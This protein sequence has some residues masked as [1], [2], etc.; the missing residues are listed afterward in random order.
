MLNEDTHFTNGPGTCFRKPAGMMQR[1]E[2]ESFV[3]P[4]IVIALRNDIRKHGGPVGLAQL[5]AKTGV[6]SLSDCLPLWTVTVEELQGQLDDHRRL[7]CL[8][9]R[10]AQ[11]ACEAKVVE[12]E[13][14]Q[15]Q[16]FAEAPLPLSDLYLDWCMERIGAL[17][18]ERPGTCPR[19][20][21]PAAHLAAIESLQDRVRESLRGSD[22]DIAT[23][24]VQDPS[25][26]GVRAGRAKARPTTTE[27]L[28]QPIPRLGAEL[29]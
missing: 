12:R 25:G 4:E 19:G 28:H 7:G 10:P 20:A 8:D 14:V 29:R 26:R 1:G 17:L 6:V 16:Q 9:G 13:W 15:Q 24:L 23:S 11:A 3:A 5:A 21:D 2:D 18:L 22:A 27:M